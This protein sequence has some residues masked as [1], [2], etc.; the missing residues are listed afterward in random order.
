M[1]GCVFGNFYGKFPANVKHGSLGKPGG[2]GAIWNK[3]RGTN[4][5]D[6]SRSNLFSQNL[7]QR[8][9][10]SPFG[11]TL[12]ELLVVIA[13]IGMLIALLLP[14]VQVA[15]EAARRM[16]CTNHLKQTGIGIH[17]FH[18]TTQGLPPYFIEAERPGFWVLLLPYIEQQSLY[19]VIT[20]YSG[21]TGIA[22]KFPVY[23]STLTTEE[24]KK[25]HGSVPIIKCPSRRSG[26]AYADQHQSGPQTDYAPIIYLRTEGTIPTGQTTASDI[27]SGLYQVA[28]NTRS[29][30][31][32]KSP[33]RKNNSP[34][35]MAGL[36]VAGNFNTWTTP[37]SFANWTD[38]TSNQLVVG[39]KYIHHDYLGKCITDAVASGLVP[40]TYSTK[41][42]R[43]D[44]SG[45]YQSSSN[46]SAMA[47]VMHNYGSPVTALVKRAEDVAT[48][49]PSYGYSC[50]SYHP[51]ICNF[52]RGDGSVIAIQN[53]TADIMLLMLA[54]VN[55]G[56][57]PELP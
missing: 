2:G 57:I 10:S 4:R 12:V 53:N 15:R 45:F 51:G 26:V 54:D 39:E 25:A 1:F 11:F 36:Q 18:G 30:Y 7:L 19:D 20:S 5:R 23:W 35:K 43:A 13:I 8:F 9:R 16:S 27:G 44:C 50:G 29:D 3:K 22:Q 6:C 56:G 37:N 41:V 52:L 34:F 38:G 33:N 49:E 46:I 28:F 31:E 21:G 24:Q 14:A 17:N 42:A 47:Y 48:R 32:T 40:S 55:D